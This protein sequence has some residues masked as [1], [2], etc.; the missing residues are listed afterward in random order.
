MFRGKPVGIPFARGRVRVAMIIHVADF[1][2]Q[3]VVQVEIANR[4]A[5]P[6]ERPV[7]TDL[8]PDAA[9]HLCFNQL[10]RVRGTSIHFHQRRFNRIK[11]NVRS[12]LHAVQGEQASLA[13]HCTKLHHLD[14]SRQMLW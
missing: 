9:K 1:M 13:R 3:D 12:P 11:I 10:L 7:L 4:V 5:S 14:R 2:N 6:V 8:L